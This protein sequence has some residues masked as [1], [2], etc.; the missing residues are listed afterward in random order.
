MDKDRRG[1]ECRGRVCAF[2]YVILEQR[3]D[4][5]RI[6]FIIRITRGCQKGGKGLIARS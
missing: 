5:I 4:G 3:R 6:I 2:Q 1:L